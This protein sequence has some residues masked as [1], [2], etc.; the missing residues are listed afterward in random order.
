MGSRESVGDESGEVKTMFSRNFTKR[1]REKNQE[2]YYLCMLF[3]EFRWVLLRVCCLSRII[4]TVIITGA[5]F[6]STMCRYGSSQHLHNS[7]NPYN[8]PM[9]ERLFLL[10]FYR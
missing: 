10:P 9:R 8:H 7:L 3:Y 6:A 2:V 5:Y 1:K 4:V